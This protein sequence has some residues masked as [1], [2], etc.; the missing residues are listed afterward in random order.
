MN[1]IE[2]MYENAN[3]EDKNI[4]NQLYKDL[5]Y[6]QFTAEKQIR[7]LN[8]LC[9]RRFIELGVTPD[10]EYFLYD[11]NC[12]QSHNQHFNEAVAKF[13]NMLWQSLTEEEKQQIKEILNVR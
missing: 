8:L 13:V 4:N 5:N 9:R 12:C 1:E 11:H 2:K 10:N 7:I 6:P 3:V